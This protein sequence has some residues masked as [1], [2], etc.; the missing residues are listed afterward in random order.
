MAFK[1][2][3]IEDQSNGI[4]IILNNGYE[5][6]IPKNEFDSVHGDS[7]SGWID[8][9]SEKTWA[10]IDS[11]YKVASIMNKH[12]KASKIDWDKTFFHIERHFMIKHVADKHEKTNETNLPWKSKQYYINR[13]FKMIEIGSLTHTDEINDIV[14]D[15]VQSSI[16]KY[17]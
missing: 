9:L 8:Q 11:L 5:Y 16:S 13:T 17:F 10:D 3:A 14:H 1:I 7:I 12:T 6:F 2:T 15:V 4:L